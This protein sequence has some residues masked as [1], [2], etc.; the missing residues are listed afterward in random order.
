MMSSDYSE[1]ILKILDAK[2]KSNSR[3]YLARGIMDERVKVI[4]PEPELF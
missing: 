2:I 3:C 1:Y 4:L